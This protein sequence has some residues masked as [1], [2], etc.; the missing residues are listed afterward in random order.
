[1]LQLNLSPLIGARPGERLTFILDEGPQQ[2]EDVSVD[3]LRGSIQ[4]TRVHGGILVEAWVDT[5]VNVECVR[6][7]ETFPYETTLEIEEVIGISSKPRPGI[8]YH[9]TDEGWFDPLPLLREQILV[10]I[11]MKP[12]CRPDCRGICPEC[13]AN[14]NLEPCLCPVEHVDPRLAPLAQLLNRKVG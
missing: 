14:L 2:I 6:C 4:F 3:F 9:L 7:L 10:N 12:L 11:P 13:G 5:R 1:M 8:S